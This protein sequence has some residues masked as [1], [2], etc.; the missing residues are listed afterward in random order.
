MTTD[1]D[2]LDAYSR[3]VTRVAETVSPSVAN[4]RLRTRGRI[5]GGGSGV[6]IAPDGFMLTSAHV[7]EGASRQITASFTDGRD[8]AVRVIGAD[9]LSDLALLL[10]GE[11]PATARD[12]STSTE[13]LAAAAESV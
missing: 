12:D 11:K 3:V 8:V 10:I 5:A 4:L 1:A 6:V 9:P 2:A 13:A 7:V